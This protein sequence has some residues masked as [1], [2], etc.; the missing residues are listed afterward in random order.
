MFKIKARSIVDLPNQVTVITPLACAEP[1]QED[2]M[3]ILS[4]QIEDVDDAQ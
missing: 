1:F 4:I 3:D 2:E